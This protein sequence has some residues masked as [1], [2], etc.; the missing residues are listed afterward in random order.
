MIKNISRI[1]VVAMLFSAFSVSSA[2]AATNNIQSDNTYQEILTRLNA[3]YAEYGLEASLEPSQT[4]SIS[5][6]PEEFE[7]RV[8]EQLQQAAEQNAR[9]KQAYEKNGNKFDEIEWIPMNNE[10]SKD[11]RSYNAYTST[12]SGNGHKATLVGVIKVD[13]NN[14]NKYFENIDSITSKAN[15]GTYSFYVQNYSYQLIDTKRTCAVAF[16]GY[17]Y[18]MITQVEVLN[19]TDYIEFYSTDKN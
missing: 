5:L 16:T 7:I 8:R 2:F 4:R 13:D 11:L 9:V 1:L 14:G 19:V 15:L 12:R 3:E 10:A 6:T 18:N 17:S